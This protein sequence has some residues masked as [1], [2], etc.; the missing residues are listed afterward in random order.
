[1]TDI[2]GSL[3]EIG[4]LQEEM[5]K[6]TQTLTY[7]MDITIRL[8]DDDGRNNIVE[9]TAAISFMTELWSIFPDQFDQKENMS[10]SALTLM[11]RAFGAQSRPLKVKSCHNEFRSLQLHV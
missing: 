1:M 6:S 9:R 4:S 5:S 10:Y 3:S 2:V 11:K 7:W 8:A